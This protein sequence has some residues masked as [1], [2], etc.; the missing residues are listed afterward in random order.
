MK[1]ITGNPA[2][3]AYQRFAVKGVS[4]AQ[5]AEGASGT[6]PRPQGTEAAKVSISTEAR[7]LASGSEQV[8]AQKV[9][10][11]KAAIE[12]GSFRVDATLVAQRMLDGLGG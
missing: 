7:E 1:G 6:A 3:D 12:D 10:R 11:L 2:L 4:S 5:R 8:N 9:E